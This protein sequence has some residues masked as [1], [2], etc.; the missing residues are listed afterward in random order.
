L[1]YPAIHARTRTH[2]HTHTHALTDT[3]AHAHTHTHRRIHNVGQHKDKYW[4]VTK[5]QNL[6]RFVKG[7]AERESKKGIEGPDARQNNTHRHSWRQAPRESMA[8]RVTPG[9][10]ATDRRL[11]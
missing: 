7:S 10:L 9:K 3:R 11:C 6:Q 8:P 5:K 2:R 1:R 4:K